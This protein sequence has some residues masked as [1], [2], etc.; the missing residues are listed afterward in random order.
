MQI[1][2][3]AAQL[4]LAQDMS[5]CLPVTDL[6]TPAGNR[7]SN[8]TWLFEKS[9]NMVCVAVLTARPQHVTY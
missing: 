2:C 5:F 3:T 6:Q 9:N 7:L 4:L 1:S 8:H